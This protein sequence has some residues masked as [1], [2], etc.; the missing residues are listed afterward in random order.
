[1]GSQVHEWRKYW[2]TDWGTVIEI[3][4]FEKKQRLYE[5]KGSRDVKTRLQEKLKKEKKKLGEYKRRHPNVVT[6]QDKKENNR[7]GK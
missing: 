6:S 1:M 4:H 2:Q 7:L 3:K 5:F